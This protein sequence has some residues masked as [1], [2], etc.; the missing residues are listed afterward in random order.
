MILSTEVQYFCLCEAILRMALRVNVKY[1]FKI[2]VKI[3][4]IT[5]RVILFFIYIL[6]NVIYQR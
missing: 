3:V 2:I 4:K 6:N 1:T 5:E